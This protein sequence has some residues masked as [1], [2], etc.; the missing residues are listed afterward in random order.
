MRYRYIAGLMR[1][2]MA[3]SLFDADERTRRLSLVESYVE[4]LDHWCDLLS[5]PRVTRLA[6]ISATP[7]LSDYRRFASGVKSVDRDCVRVREK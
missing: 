3:P 2:T 6:G 4:F 7:M 5:L 1:D